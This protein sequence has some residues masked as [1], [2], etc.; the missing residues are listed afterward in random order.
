MPFSKFYF[1]F[2]SYT[3]KQSSRTM[4]TTRTVLKRGIQYNEPSMACF[5]RLIPFWPGNRLV[6]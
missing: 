3:S 4:S 1:I 6:A 5:A 2:E